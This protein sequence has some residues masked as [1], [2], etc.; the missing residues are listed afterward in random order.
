MEE[1]A[2]V[3]VLVSKT[4]LRRIV[5]GY[6]TFERGALYVGAGESFGLQIV[7]FS[8]EGCSIR[9]GIVR[10]YIRQGKRWKRWKGPIPKVVHNRLLPFTLTERRGLV[11]L[12]RHVRNGLFNGL[13]SR[14]KWVVWEHLELDD[15]VRNYLPMTWPL[16]VAARRR[17]HKRL[18]EYGSLVLKP[19]RG[20]VGIGVICVEQTRGSRLQRRTFPGGKVRNL[21]V[22]GARRVLR[23]FQ[24]KR[25]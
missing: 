21:T 23:Q 5:K 17:F 7:L 3:G 22:R 24:A 11:R 14:D 12:S 19:R 15:R 2:S 6:P 4:M 1:Q 13:V 20:G 8:I 25:P 18:R 10:G 9:H 16:T